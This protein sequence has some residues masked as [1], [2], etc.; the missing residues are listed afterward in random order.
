M[1]TIK[2][3]SKGH[4]YTYA[5]LA[6]YEKQNVEIP[7][8][9]TMANEFGE[10]VQY[11]DDNGDWH[12]GAKVVIPGENARMNAAQ[13]YGAALTYARRY[14]VALATA[15]VT[16]DDAAVENDNWVKPAAANNAKLIT[17]SQIALIKRLAEEQDKPVPDDLEDWSSARA[18][19]VIEKLIGNSKGT[20]G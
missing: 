5:S 8:M 20:E 12:Q 4:G 1:S 14:T 9:R 17:H 16:A 10:W 13:A 11:R 7:V 2:N 19:A 18:S 15:T 6:D 3:L